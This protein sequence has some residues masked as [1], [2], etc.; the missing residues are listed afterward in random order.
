VAIKNVNFS[1]SVP[2][3]QLLMLIANGNAALKID[4][5]G[6][7]KPAKMVKALNGHA[8][9]LLEGPKAKTGNISRTFLEF[10]AARPAHDI[11][12][13]DMI[14]ICVKMGG[15]RNTGNTMMSHWRKGGLVKHTG[16]ATYQLTAAGLRECAKRG[17]EV[18]TK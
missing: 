1:F 18:A 6:N 17:I 10:M 11:R 4:V 13:A 16:P 5:Y 7:D 8:P 3:E 9:K 12:G 2:I 15:H 14:A